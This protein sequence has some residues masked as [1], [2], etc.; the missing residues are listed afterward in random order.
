MFC[1]APATAD[2]VDVRVTEAHKNRRQARP[3]TKAHSLRCQGREFK[4]D[5]LRILSL[6]C[7]TS[8]VKYPIGL[9]TLFLLW[10]AFA[11]AQQYLDI[12]SGTA[13]YQFGNEFIDFHFAGNG[14][15]GTGYFLLPDQDPFIFVRPAGPFSFGVI[16]NGDLFGDTPPRPG[17]DGIDAQRGPATPT[18]GRWATNSGHI[19]WKQRSHQR[20]WDFLRYL[21]WQCVL[22]RHT[23]QRVRVYRQP[24]F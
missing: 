24:R 7:G 5:T 11:S 15:S 3:S 13:T 4:M 21:F 18:G 20:H 10:P 22:R 19:F 16:L 14:F 9:L 1:H 12:K 8:R 2:S 6:V 17:P 23:G